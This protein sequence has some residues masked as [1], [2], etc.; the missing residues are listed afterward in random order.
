M[1]RTVELNYTLGSEVVTG[2][3]HES[4]YTFLAVLVN[5][6]GRSA[7]FTSRANTTIGKCVEVASKCAFESDDHYLI[8]H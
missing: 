4:S 7:R 3:N 6:A 1:E 8:H 5:S 2:L